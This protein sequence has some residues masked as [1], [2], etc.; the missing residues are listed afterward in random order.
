MAIEL[1]ITFEVVV[2]FVLAFEDGVV[3][4]I[5]VVVALLVATITTLDVVDLVIAVNLLVLL[6]VGANAVE[7]GWLDVVPVLELD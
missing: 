2:G 7:L 5:A 3:V 1:L 4:L 6:G